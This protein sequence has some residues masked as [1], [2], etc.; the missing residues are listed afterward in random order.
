MTSCLLPE[1]SL[2]V[3][4]SL[5]TCPLVAPGAFSLSSAETLVQRAWPL[6]ALEWF[7]LMETEAGLEEKVMPTVL[8]RT[9]I[10]KGGIFFA[11]WGSR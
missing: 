2:W 11:M 8:G 9:P 4:I 10:R 1:C 6:A 3:Q 5:R 7:C